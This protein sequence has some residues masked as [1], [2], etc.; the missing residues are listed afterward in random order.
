MAGSINPVKREAFIVIKNYI[1]HLHSDCVVTSPASPTLN[2]PATGQLYVD[3]Y[4]VTISWVSMKNSSI[5]FGSFLRHLG[6]H[7]ALI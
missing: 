2:S 4:N 6:E 3:T 1:I 5:N 7:S